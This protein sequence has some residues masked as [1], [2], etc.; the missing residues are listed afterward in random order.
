MGRS[1]R[2]KLEGRM[3]RSLG[4]REEKTVS[5]SSLCLQLLLIGSADE[6]K[7]IC[8][9]IASRVEKRNTGKQETNMSKEI[10]WY[11]NISNVVKILRHILKMA[12]ME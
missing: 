2:R 5:V 4:R 10:Y 12:I 9:L 1:P 7:S 6:N 8:G 11:L 3:G